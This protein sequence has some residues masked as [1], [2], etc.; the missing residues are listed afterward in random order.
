M[1]AVVQL[2]VVLWCSYRGAVVQLSGCCVPSC[3]NALF[4]LHFHCPPSLSLLLTS[5]GLKG[6]SLF[7]HVN[8]YC[9]CPVLELSNQTEYF[10]LF[11][12]RI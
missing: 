8:L 7:E 12:V 1:S 9:V 2:S 4:S 10:T 5:V 6:L 3:L 11:N